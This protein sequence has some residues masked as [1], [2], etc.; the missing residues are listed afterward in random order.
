MSYKVVR[1]VGTYI[2]GF[3]YMKSNRIP[4]LSELNDFSN[5]RVLSL[6][7]KPH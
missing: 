5:L 7:T 6:N 1:S 2:G 4:A 3:E